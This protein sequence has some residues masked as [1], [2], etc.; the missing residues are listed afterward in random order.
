MMIAPGLAILA[1]GEN[2]RLLALAPENKRVWLSSQPPFKKADGHLTREGY[3][4][5]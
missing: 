4:Q 3:K 2:A 5:G 1:I